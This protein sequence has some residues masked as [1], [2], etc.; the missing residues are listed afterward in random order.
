M[1]KA[2]WALIIVVVGYLAYLL[3]LQ[4]Q[5][6]ESEHAGQR[7]E[8]AAAI[9]NGDA[10]PGMP[11]QLDASYRVAKDRGAAAFRS[12]FDANQHQLADP[13]K[14]WIQLELCRMM[15]REN[16]SEA[17]KIYAEVKSR[18]PPSSPVWPEVKALERTLGQ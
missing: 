1:T 4:W 17:K 3:F 9:V 5:Q 16:P 13:R 10:L 12:W 11:Y 2:I 18:V 8:A 7:K 6:A 15:T 14:A